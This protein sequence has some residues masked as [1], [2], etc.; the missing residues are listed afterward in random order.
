MNPNANAILTLCSHLCVCEGVVPLEP[1]EYSEFAQ[2]LMAAG[3]KPGSLFEMSGSDICELMNAD[4]GFAVRI[5]RLIDRNASLCFELEKLSAMGIEAV[6]RAEGRYPAALKKKLSGNCPP[7]F[8]YAGD[9]SLLN[10][11]VIG[12]AG[13]RTVEQ[14][15]IDFTMNTVRKIVS[16]GYGVVSGGA[17]GIDAVAGTESILSGSFSIEYLSDSMLR[18]MRS[19]ETVKKIQNGD[20]L[21]LSVVKPDAGF[22]VG[23]A[24]MRNHYIYAQSE[25]TVVV[26]SDLNKGGTWTGAME[27][28]R[29][30]WCP[31]LC[32]D[33]AYPGNQT[34]I[35]K[36]AT[37][38]D[39]N[40][41]GQIPSLQPNAEKSEETEQ[42]SLFDM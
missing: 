31:T 13:A 7:I 41:D 16:I 20:L 15:D 27:N 32:W 8:Y 3:K 9:M 2:K 1:K 34:L 24:M 37:A 28:I 29:H 25:A 33:Y 10:R 6:T 11:R 5:L 22:H 30:G 18:K 23:I 40:W 19:S 35:E 26:R 39:D 36:G 12:F 21:L 38:I 14:Q 42:L 17:K 4:E